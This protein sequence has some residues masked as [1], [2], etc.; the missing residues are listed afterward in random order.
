MT[1]TAL[2]VEL[3]GLGA[4]LT[5]SGDRLRCRAPAGVLTPQHRAALAHHKA[6]LLGLL[7]GPPRLEVVDPEVIPPA[8]PAARFHDLNVEVQLSSPVFG[9]VWLVRAYTGCRR[10]ELTPADV[11]AIRLVQQ[12]F[13]GSAVISIRR[14]QHRAD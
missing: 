4:E 14:R 6:E 9:D 10:P 1:A 2:L 8:G 7:A 3:R 11:D 13:P 5:T 12:E